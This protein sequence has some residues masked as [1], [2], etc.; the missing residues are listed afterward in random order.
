MDQLKETICY[1]FQRLVFHLDSAPFEAHY[2][3]QKNAKENKKQFRVASETILQSKYMDSSMA[4]MANDDEAVKLV[5]QLKELWKK[6]GMHL[7][8]WLSNSKKVLVE[9]DM[10]DRAK[11]IDVSLDDLPLVKILGVM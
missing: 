6:T 2:N 1:G 5:Q 7:R 3:S 10:K 8:M 9:T 11:Q 4:N